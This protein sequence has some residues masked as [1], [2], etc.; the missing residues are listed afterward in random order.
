M[1]VV[2]ASVPNVSV[3]RSHLARE[4]TDTSHSV[5]SSH[6]PGPLS[7]GSYC[8][9]RGSRIARC[10]A[11][12]NL[13]SRNRS[14]LGGPLRSYALLGPSRPYVVGCVCCRVLGRSYR[15][16]RCTRMRIPVYATG[17][18]CT[19]ACGIAG[20]VSREGCK[21]RNCTH[22]QARGVAGISPYCKRCL[23]IQACRKRERKVFMK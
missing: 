16:G 9:T 7:V 18:A 11:L 4:G 3:N 20:E 10:D 15:P 21:T 5:L 19:A 6:G 17:V 13:Q 8:V 14:A 22:P 23:Y 12:R 2:R 1:L